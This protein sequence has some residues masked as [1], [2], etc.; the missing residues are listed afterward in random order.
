MLRPLLE[1]QQGSVVHFA[2]NMQKS[3]MQEVQ[4]RRVCVRKARAH[5]QLTLA[6]GCQGQQ[7]VF[8]SRVVVS[9]R[10]VV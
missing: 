8:K 7:D 6:R 10:D 3:S 9:R 1:A 4:A 5:L 2:F